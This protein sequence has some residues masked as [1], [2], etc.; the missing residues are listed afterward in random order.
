MPEDA[1]G[2]EEIDEVLRQT[3]RI[4]LITQNMLDFSRKQNFDR[5][6]VS[7]NQ[8]LEEILEQINHHMPLDQVEIRF[9]PAM[10][11]PVYMGDAE[12]L[13]QVF[14]NLIV[15]GLQAM[16]G[17]GELS[18]ESRFHETEICVSI[19]DSG[20]GVSDEIQA[21]IF[22]PFF[23]SKANGTGLGLFV[24]YGIIRAHG[25]EIEVQS[26]EGRGSRFIVHLDQPIPA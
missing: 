2:H 16:E 13:R 17:I 15:N 18:V 14:I 8:L 10:D 7:I 5:Q 19:A 22:N 6:E 26:H 9:D 3:E 20:P 1:E 12:R 4:S 11:L 25:G 21:Q 24:S 23:T